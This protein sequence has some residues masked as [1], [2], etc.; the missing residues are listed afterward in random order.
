VNLLEKIAKIFVDVGREKERKRFD[1]KTSTNYIED[2]VVNLFNI[3]Q[4][5]RADFSIGIRPF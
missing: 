4:K 1:F 3:T 5:E 2:K